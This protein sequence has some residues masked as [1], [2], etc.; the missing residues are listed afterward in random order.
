MSIPST[1]IDRLLSSIN[2]VDVIG[3]RLTLE[4]KG[5]AYWAK[6]PFH[7]SGEER[8]AS[9]KV[10]EETGTYHCFGCKESGNAVHFLRKHDGLDFLEAVETLATQVGMEIPKQEAPVD[11]S[12]ATKINN[13]ASQVFYEQLKSDLGKKTIKYLKERGITGETAKFFQLG[14]SSNKKPTL[15][16]NLKNEFKEIDLDESGLF[17][18]NDDGEYYDRFRDRLMF[19]IRNIKGECIAF[20]GRLLSD[21]KDQAKYLNSPETKTYKKKYELYGLY[22]IREINKRPESIFLVE[23]YMDVIGLFQHGIKNAVASSG[24]AFTQEQ[25]RK[26]LSYTNTI[27][28][29]FDG[30][31]AGYKASWR[32]VENALPLLR[33]DTRISFIFLELDE[34]PDSYVSSN[35]KDA[36][37]NLA[38]EA[39]SFSDF[40]FDYVKDQDN[41]STL[42]GRSMVAKFVLPL[43][44]KISNDT[45]KEAYINEVSKICDLDFSKLIQGESKSKKISPTKKEEVKES[46]NTVLR[47]SVLGI[48]TAL[49]QHPKLSSINE[50]SLITHESKFNFINDIKNLYQDSPDSN[51]SIIFEKIESERI[52][53]IFGEAL[54]SEVKL[55]EEDATSMI[56]DCLKIISQTNSE[57]E[58]IL[59]EKYNMQELTSAEKRELQQI[60]LKKDKMS[61]DEE[62]LIKNLSSI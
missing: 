24:T 61:Q 1:F 37:L 15:Y 40:F 45:L 28:I 11:T 19:P 26:I 8:T 23:G 27:Y 12:N 3:R 56:K 6:C 5:G 2:I 14:Y 47:K 46:T 16:E 29:V 4:R 9:F 53:N 34:D 33:E 32:A 17:G 58:E 44:N 48:F 43:V 38:K 59:K 57:R 49:I 18:K 35:G 52:K 30:D 55:S 7:G 62:A 54:V 20:G 36:F 39:K 13:R 60:I 22:E 25:L 21:K 41:L 31:E 42:E 50:F 51:P 10:Y